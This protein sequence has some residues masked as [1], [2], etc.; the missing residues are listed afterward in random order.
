MSGRADETWFP[1]SFVAGGWAQPCRSLR[2]HGEC[3][4]ALA[5]PMWG[6]TSKFGICLESAKDALS[7][8]FRQLCLFRVSGCPEQCQS[9][10]N[11]CKIHTART[12]GL[13]WSGQRDAL[14]LWNSRTHLFYWMEMQHKPTI[15]I[16]SLVVFIPYFFCLG[17]RAQHILPPPDLQPILH[18]S[19]CGLTFALSTVPEP[20]EFAFCS[21]WGIQ[22]A[23][24]LNPIH[25]STGDTAS[26]PHKS[27][28]LLEAPGFSVLY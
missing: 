4:P 26:K 7:M 10:P 5:S 25:F 8:L 17:F 2:V 22:T 23:K 20:S 11:G 13:T 19:L 15:P 27:S 14:T 28:L 3:P 18:P 9:S 16:Q 6:T 12:E 1:L 24:H 21:F